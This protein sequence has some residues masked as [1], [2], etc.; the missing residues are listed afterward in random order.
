MGNGCVGTV[1]NRRP[2][3]CKPSAL[4]L[5]YRRASGWEHTTRAGSGSRIRPAHSNRGTP[6]TSTAAGVSG[7]QRLYIEQ[8]RSC[9]PH[10]SRFWQTLQEHAGTGVGRGISGFC[11]SLQLAQVLVEVPAVSHR[12]V[13]GPGDPAVLADHVGGAARAALLL[14]EDLERPRHLPVRP[15]V[16]EQGEV[17]VVRVGERAH[18]IDRVARSEEHTSELQSLMRISYA[19]FCLKKKKTNEILDI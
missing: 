2:L 6:R 7:P 8:S 3:G 16:G 10:L 11:G 1:S 14:V 5:S 18:R 12:V 15:E 9:G 4:P 13:H 19:V 17:Q